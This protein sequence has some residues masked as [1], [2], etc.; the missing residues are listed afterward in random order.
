MSFTAKAMFPGDLHD[1]AGRLA[2]ETGEKLANVKEAA[3][4]ESLYAVAWK[5]AARLGWCGILIPEADGGAG[6]TLQDVAALAEATSRHALALPIVPACA[7]APALLAASVPGPQRAARA[8]HV[9]EGS[10]RVAAVFAEDAVVAR[11]RGDGYL[12]SGIANAVDVTG[13][14]THLLL[15]CRGGGE[16][17][18]A[19]FVVPAH[20]AGVAQTAYTG[21]D[22]RITAD[23]AF[24]GCRVDEECLLARGDSVIN[25]VERARRAGAAIACVEVVAAAG[26]LI[27]ETIG[28]LHTR[29]QFGFPLARLDV[30]RHKV[31]EMYVAYEN[32]KA[33]VGSVVREAEAGTPGWPRKVSLAKLY[34]GEVGRFVA[35]AG[36]QLHGAMGMTEELLAARLARRM[37][38]AEFDY[39]DRMYHLG[40][41][42][43][44]QPL[45]E[46]RSARRDREMT[47]RSM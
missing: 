18:A 41:L 6:G 38:M 34:A 43:G 28:Y 39:G 4:A 24:T 30:L 10:W 11:S 20:Q 42:A 29:V 22:G 14:P 5:Q 15:A 26:R 40:R 36:I 44:M 23:I 27:E 3:A 9:S 7:V 25:A 19:I 47:Q 35:H 45:V 31:A 37:L 21:M 17:E 46:T 12:I 2:R 13:A 1:V 33:L 16:T 8:A 32:L